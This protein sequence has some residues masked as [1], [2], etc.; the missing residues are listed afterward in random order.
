M[1]IGARR[2]DPELYAKGTPKRE[3]FTQFS[4]TDNLRRAALENS[5]SFIRLHRHLILVIPSEVE[6]SRGIIRRNFARCLDFA[7][8]DESET[9]RYLFLFSNSRISSIVIGLV[10]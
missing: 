8:Q 1:N 9:P 4:F 2:I 3:L 6:K 7:P 5:E 10:G